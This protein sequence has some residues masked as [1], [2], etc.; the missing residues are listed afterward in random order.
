MS[1]ARVARLRAGFS[2]VEVVVA[3]TIFSGGI[4]ALS[5]AFHHVSQH[6]VTAER[7]HQAALLAERQLRA[8][9]PADGAASGRARMPVGPFAWQRRTDTVAPGL[10]RTQVA[11]TWTDGGKAEHFELQRLQRV[12]PGAEAAP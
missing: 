10:L 7:R 3:L 2:L 6:A 12:A 4:V 8:E 1:R 5:A 11:V 9:P